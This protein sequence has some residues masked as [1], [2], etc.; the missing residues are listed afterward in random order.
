LTESAKL[1]IVEE[2]L[3]IFQIAEY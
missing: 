2:E 1:Y 3:R